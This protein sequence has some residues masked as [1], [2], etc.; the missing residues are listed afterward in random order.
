MA[1]DSLRTPDGF[2]VQPDAERVAP[3]ERASAS[4]QH[5]KHSPRRCW[6]AARRNV[7]ACA[8]DSGRQKVKGGRE[9]TNSG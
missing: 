1:Q 8:N 4:H 3:P 6:Q 7:R 9:A 5:G 2:P